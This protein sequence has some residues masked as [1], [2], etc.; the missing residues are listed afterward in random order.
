MTVRED[1]WRARAPQ[2]AVLASVMLAHLAVGLWLARAAPRAS[3]RHAALEVFFIAA[4]PVPESAPAPAF[5]QAPARREMPRSR[6]R[7]HAT[8]SAPPD[9]SSPSRAPAPAMAPALDTPQLLDRLRAAARHDGLRPLAPHDPMRHRAEAL[10]GRAE[11][12]T[13]SAVV[14]REEL[15]PERIVAMIGA[16]T[17]GNYDPC[18]DTVSR[19]RDLAAR[20]PPG[21][22]RELAL[23]IDRERRRG[24]RR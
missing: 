20:N 17:G 24:C 13:P 9:V 1:R 10:P 14:L 12:F 6:I 16:L 15:T 2:A 11:P 22:D 4:D 5:P 7:T 18:P 3:A 8:P 21:G 23:L 19:I